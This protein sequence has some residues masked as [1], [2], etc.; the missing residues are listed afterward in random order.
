MVKLNSIKINNLYKKYEKSENYAIDN[1]SLDLNKP[2]IYSIVGPNGAGKTTIL[3]LISG[4]IKPTG[5]SISVDGLTF[6]LPETPAYYDNLSALDHYNLINNIVNKNDI[7]FSP[8]QIL[9]IVNLDKNKLAK[10]YSKGMKRRLDIGMAL[11]IKSDII[12]F[13]EPFDGLDPSISEQLSSIIKKMNDGRH[14][15]IISSHDLSRIEDISDTIIFMKSGKIIK[16]IGNIKNK[17]ITLIIKGN[18]ANT[19]KILNSGIEYNLIGKSITVNILK[20]DLP[21][22][23]KK[24]DNLGIEIEDIQ[25][26]NM[27]DLYRSIIGDKND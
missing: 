22:T 5:G 3:K 2:G 20:T 27:L 25:I 17:Q 13:D 10:D 6:Y 7:L 14:I 12:L 23:I 9:N 8:E 26:L 24:L 11:M 19:G 4:I 15:I 21:A 16:E 1:M 18:E